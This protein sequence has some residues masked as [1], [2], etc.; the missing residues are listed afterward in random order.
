MTKKDRLDLGAILQ[1]DKETYAIVPH[2]AG[3]IC[4][5]E[6]LKN[7]AQVAEKYNAKAI[8]VTGAQRLAIVGLNEQ[9]LEKV[10]KELEMGPG[11]AVG[12]CVRSVK[13]CPGTILQTWTAGCCENGYEIR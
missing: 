3:G 9:D 7:I 13:F 12:M 1:R 2:M 8:K 4:T 10:W 11:A 5:P 6:I